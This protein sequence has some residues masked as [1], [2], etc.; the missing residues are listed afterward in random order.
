MPML[1]FVWRRLEIVWSS[2]RR[3]TPERSS[4]LTRSIDVTKPPYYGFDPNSVTLYLKAIPVK[5]SRWEVLDTVKH[6]PGFV[7]LSLSEPLKSQEFVRYAWV[8]YDSED[9]C[10]KGKLLL[11][12]AKINSFRLAPIKS[13]SIKKPARITPP[14]AE[15][16]EKVDLELSRKLIALLDEE[17]EIAEN[18]LWKVENEPLK[19]LDLQILYLRKV[20]GLCYYSAEEYDDERILSARCGP[21]YLRSSARIPSSKLNEYVNTR[22][23]Q[24]RIDLYVE[25][26]LAKGPVKISKVLF[27]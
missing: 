20:H 25:K 10:A 5:I 12:D 22:I 4:S 1:T 2:A 6:T 21:I 27:Y 24:E 26:R 15:G 7:S 18:E 19:Q 13:Q 3:R 8:S 23:F 11:E 16:R 14:L 17:K 9:N